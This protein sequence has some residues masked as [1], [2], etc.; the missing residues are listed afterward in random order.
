M[1]YYH[2]AKKIDFSSKIYTVRTDTLTKWFMIQVII[3]NTDIMIQII[4]FIKIWKIG[5]IRKSWYRDFKFIRC[6]ELSSW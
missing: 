6:I 2:L 5:S 1:S 3:F 4:E